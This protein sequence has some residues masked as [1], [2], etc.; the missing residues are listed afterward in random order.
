MKEISL[1]IMTRELCRQFFRGH[2]SDPAVFTDES[3]YRPY[4]YSEEAA[5]RF[6]ER[7]QVPGRLELV[8]MMDG[9]T[10][11]HVQLKNI[12]PKK[13]ECEFGFHMQNDSVKGLGYGTQIARLALDYAF[14]N[15]DVDAVYAYAVLRNTRSQHVLEK[16]GFRYIDEK[17]GYR[18]YRYLRKT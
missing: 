3:Q 12:D 5:D 11:G 9:Q 17:D 10:I 16:V 4:V 6:Y 14:A 15:L 13:R 7:K 2:E 8:A 18:R 1:C